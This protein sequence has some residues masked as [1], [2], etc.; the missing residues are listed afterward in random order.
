LTGGNGEK[1]VQDCYANMTEDFSDGSIRGAQHVRGAFF[2][3]QK[4]NQGVTQ[5][6]GVDGDLKFGHSV[7]RRSNPLIP[8]NLRLHPQLLAE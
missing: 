1:I 3:R 4:Q 2:A 8:S 6:R 7:F 5:I